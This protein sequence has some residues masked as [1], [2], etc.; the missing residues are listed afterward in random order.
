MLYGGMPRLLA[1]T[2]EKDKKESSELINYQI[3]GQIYIL[4]PNILT[5]GEHFGMMFE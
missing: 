4:F 1:L 3:Y 5:I 2:D